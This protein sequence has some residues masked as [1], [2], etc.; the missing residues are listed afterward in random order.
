MG[1][2]LHSNTDSRA[3][4]VF[5]NP[6]TSD[7]LQDPMKDLWSC[8]A[9]CAG[10]N[11]LMPPHHDD[12]RPICSKVYAEVFSDRLRPPWQDSIKLSVPLSRSRD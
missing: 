9:E 3:G 11:I 6:E 5:G 8:I 1:F 4:S 2:G 10:Q 12:T 7:S